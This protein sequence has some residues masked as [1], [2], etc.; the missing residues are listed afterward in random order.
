[1][2]ARAEQHHRIDDTKSR[3]I[4]D[5]ALIRELKS[6]VGAAHVLAG[7]AAR[8]YASVPQ[9]PPAHLV[10]VLP[11]SLVELWRA[12]RAA[13]RARRVVVVLATGS[14]RTGSAGLAGDCDRGV[15][16]VKTL[17]LKRTH[18]MNAGAQAVCL[19]GTTL[20]ELERELRPLH[21]ESQFVIS[22]AS[23]RTSVVGSVCAGPGASH[24]RRGPAYTEAAIYA[25]VDEAGELRLVNKLGIDLG[26]D[27]EEQL[28]KL[29]RGDFDRVL[30]DMHERAC[31]APGYVDKVRDTGSASPAR[32]N[33][34][35]RYLKDASGCAGHLI[36]FAVRIDTF[37][38]ERNTRI[39]HL[40]TDNPAILTDIRRK[41]LAA[42]SLL[43]V[44]AEYLSGSF[45]HLI[46]RHGQDS[47]L[48][49]RL[50]KSGRIAPLLA[51]YGLAGRLAQRVLGGRRFQVKRLA[52][53]VGRYLP[54]RPPEEFQRLGERYG[55]HL[56]LRVS[57]AQKTAVRDLLKQASANGGG[58][59]VEYELRDGWRVMHTFHSAAGAVERYSELSRDA[60]RRVVTFDV[61]LRRNDKAWFYVLPDH[62]RRMVRKTYVYGHFFCHVFHQN[63][64]LKDAADAAAFRRGM[65]AHYQARGAAYPAEQPIGHQHVATPDQV[66]FFQKL[67]PTNALN[68][69]VAQTSRR[70]NW[71]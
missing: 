30:N 53:A 57:A 1:M 31:S 45:F 36:V 26:R 16:I 34:D 60:S 38:E 56:L 7:P 46:A 41:M 29:E 27:P 68:A 39:F 35:K 44:G 22:S 10:A 8:R 20:L 2:T 67:D 11:G 6:I 47:Y 59:V 21:R 65:L 5:A 71:R 58:V 64:V 54:Y 66:A 32:W 55:H 17:R 49:M 62:L 70:P 24:L 37:P 15:V 42:D 25:H 51:L 18:L 61:A 48:A 63:F 33:T 12:A 13:V 3:M 69:G 40:A 14:V 19:P 28:E 23:L 50:A 43:P 9:D 4:S 52:Q